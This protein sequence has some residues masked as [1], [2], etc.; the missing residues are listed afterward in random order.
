MNAMA[1]TTVPRRPEGRR[2]GNRGGLG[3]WDW[4]LVG[5]VGVAVLLRL[6]FLTS[7]SLWYDEASSW[8]TAMFPPAEMLE[9]LCLNVHMPLYYLLLKGWI[10]ALG[11]SIASLRG[12]SIVF[13]AVT[14][15]GM[16]L[17][18]RELYRSSASGDEDDAGRRGFALAV[19]GLVAVSPFQVLGS[20]EVRMYSLGTAFTAISGWLLLRILRAEGRT[21][22]WWPYGAACVGLLYTHHYGLFTVAAQ[23]LF[24]AIE[25]AWLLGRGERARARAVLKG[26]SAAGFLIALAYLPGLGI[27][28]TQAGR[29]RQE[30]WLPELTWRKFSGTFSE[31]LI[32]THGFDFEVGGW[33]V[34]GVAAASCAIVAWRGRRGDRLVLASALVPMLAAGA[35][36]TAQPLWLARYF[37]FAH[38]FILCVVALAAWKIS[39]NAPLSRKLLV[40]M[41][42]SAQFVANTVCVR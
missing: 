6:P 12:F 31:F 11:D 15:V 23:Y 32:P 1:P 4:G 29:V 24:L 41:L 27:L 19:A 5:V 9:S 2:E 35:L 36:S 30:Y 21:W 34:F 38:L 3:A 26:A 17:F 13:G 10:A 16:D 8:Q 18:A 25:L 42:F 7:R 28:R 40:V 20:I 33:I 37:R 22:L 39:R 14:V